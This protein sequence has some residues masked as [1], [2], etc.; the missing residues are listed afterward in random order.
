MGYDMF[1]PIECLGQDL[2]D[3]LTDLGFEAEVVE[4]DDGKALEFSDYRILNDESHPDYDDMFEKWFDNLFTCI[5]MSNE[6]GFQEIYFIWSTGEIHKHSN[7]PDKVLTD[8]QDFMENYGEIRFIPIPDN[9]DY[10]V[11]DSENEKEIPPLETVSLNKEEIRKNIRKYFS[12]NLVTIDDLLKKINDSLKE[13][14]E[15]E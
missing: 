7:L 15:E 9:S 1:N 4:V 6:E 8:V 12:E 11:S 5:R 2:F 14:G 3:Y 10:E 13:S